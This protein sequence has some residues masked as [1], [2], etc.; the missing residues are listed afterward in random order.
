MPR[1][2]Y[3]GKAGRRKPARTPAQVIV[4]LAGI[5][6]AVAFL[7]LLARQSPP[8]AVGVFMALVTFAW[9]EWKKG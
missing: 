3:V 7:L 9:L 1:N 5:P 4:W 2:R 8:L 6:V